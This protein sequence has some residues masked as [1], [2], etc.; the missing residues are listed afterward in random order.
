MTL[1]DA[2][3]RV[4]RPRA[5][6]G[7]ILDEK[8]AEF[9]VDKAIR[10]VGEDI[11]RDSGIQL[12][13]NEHKGSFGN[14]KGQQR[15]INRMRRHAGPS[16]LQ[17]AGTTNKKSF[18]LL[19]DYL[20]VEDDRLAIKRLSLAHR[21]HSKART[22]LS[23]VLLITRHALVRS[24]QRVDV[25][26]TE[27]VFGF[28]RMVWRSLW[29]VLMAVEQRQL[30]TPARTC[31][32]IPADLDQRTRGLLVARPTLD[33]PPA[34]V[35]LYPDEWIPDAKALP[36]AELTRLLGDLELGEPVVNDA[37]VEILPKLLV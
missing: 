37:I 9:F 12:A 34:L 23:E 4:Q 16:T 31:W 35:T 24:V 19:W 25:R 2:R 30:T 17:I 11:E 3:P 1:V 15:L 5:V 33:E 36:A 28:L 13:L 32:L 8:T 18:D 14:I 22:D 6:R 26:S 20:V 29:R 10:A 27:D 7:V 21:R